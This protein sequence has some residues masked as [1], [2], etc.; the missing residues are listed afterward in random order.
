MK[1][2]ILLSKTPNE[3]EI[4][5]VNISYYSAKLGVSIFFKKVLIFWL[6]KKICSAWLAVKNTEKLLKFYLNENIAECLL[7]SL[8]NNKCAQI[9]C[10]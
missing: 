7:L 5:A 10:I 6:L 8:A 2:E 9:S 3:H 1:S 4:P